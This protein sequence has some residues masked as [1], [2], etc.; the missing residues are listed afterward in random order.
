MPGLI[1][2]LCAVT[3]LVSAVLLLRGALS[4]GG[5]GLL[6][7]SSLCFFAMAAN[8]V[9]LYMNYIVFPDVDLLMASRLATVLGIVLLNIGLIWHST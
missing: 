7:W 8:N 9:L 6:F 4:R 1:Y 2:I 3:S 5:G